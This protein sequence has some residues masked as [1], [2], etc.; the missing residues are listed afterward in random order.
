MGKGVRRGR[1]PLQPDRTV[2]PAAIGARIRAA[3]ERVGLKQTEAGAPRYSA[4]YISAVENGHHLPS[5]EALM[6][7]ANNLG[8]GPGELL[9]EPTD[10][11]PAATALARALESVQ[12]DLPEAA[13]E[14]RDALVAAQFVLRQVL[15]R[16]QGA[17]KN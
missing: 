7:I 9:T 4:A 5:V 3:R 13:G 14:R 8:V 15:L 12:R 1:R 2:S 17:D 16:L 6:L 10:I 11:P